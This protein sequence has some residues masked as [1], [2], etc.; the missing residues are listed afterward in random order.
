[1]T[2]T[3]TGQVHKITSNASGTYIITDLPNGGYSL[4]VSSPGFSTYLQKDIVLDVGTNPE[5][6]VRLTL[7]SVT[8]EVVV[9]SNQAQVETVSNGIGQVIDSTQIVELP[10][11]GRDPDQLIALAG[12]T[13]S[14]PGGD[15]N[16][17]K[18]FPTIT[19]SVAGG[20]PNAVAFV[21]D[22]GTHNE[23]TNNLNMPQP[24]PD[25]LEEFRV[26]TSA[27]PAQYGGPFIRG[28]Q[29]SYQERR[30]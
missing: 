9:E 28:H 8:Q 18:N 22:G 19:I 6:N 25:A 30:Q 21:L 20:L 29:C 27:L 12:A 17:N 15:L 3:D 10:L 11:N 13:T 5:I 26:E 2:Q 14:A 1:M 7:G 24:F 16:S 23:P 4:Q